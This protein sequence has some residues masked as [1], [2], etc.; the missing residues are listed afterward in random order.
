M[1]LICIF[2]SVSSWEDDVIFLFTITHLFSNYF[3]IFYYGIRIN[4]KC[5][6]KWVWAQ[7]IQCSF[8]Q[9]TSTLN[10]CYVFTFLQREKLTGFYLKVYLSLGLLKVLRA[11]FQVGKKKSSSE[12]RYLILVTKEIISLI[13]KSK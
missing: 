7:L 4:F 12:P 3:K 10:V 5:G 1:W 13:K 6:E 11:K 9:P 8:K 2:T